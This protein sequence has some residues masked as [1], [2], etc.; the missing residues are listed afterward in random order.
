MNLNGKK[1]YR[2]INEVIE[3]TIEVPKKY[4]EL[5]EL[6]RD[7]PNFDKSPGAKKIYQRKE[8]TIYRVKRGY[9]VHNTKKAFID[10]HTHIYNYNKAKNIIDLA[11]R[12]KMPNT[13]KKWEIECLLRIIKDEK[14][15][16]ELRSLL[17]EIK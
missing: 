15:K 17:E 13:P 1:V 9:I 4:W 14:Y 6:M 5:E 8:Y 2:D 10:G 3:A 16:E 11:I 7:K 12:K